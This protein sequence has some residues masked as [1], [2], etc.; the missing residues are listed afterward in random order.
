MLMVRFTR[1]S[2]IRGGRISSEEGVEGEEET[3]EEGFGDL[4]LPLPQSREE[5]TPDQV[6][7]PAFRSFFLVMMIMMMIFLS[8]FCFVAGVVDDEDDDDDVL[9]FGV[10][11]FGVVVDGDDDVHV[12]VVS[13]LWFMFLLL[14]MTMIHIN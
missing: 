2:E 1:R 10:L 12:F 11:V 6:R 8:F 4:G 3:D 13:L 7:S 9:V 5:S 14:T